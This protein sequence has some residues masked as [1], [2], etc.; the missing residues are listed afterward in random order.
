[1]ATITVQARALGSDSRLVDKIEK[2]L[3]RALRGELRLD[4]DSL[5]APIPSHLKVWMDEHPGEFQMAE[6][7]IPRP[8][9]RLIPPREP[10]K[11]VPPP[12]EIKPYVPEPDPISA[13]MHADIQRQIREAEAE[14]LL[15]DMEKQGLILCEENQTALASFLRERSLEITRANVLHFL[16][17][18]GPKLRWRSVHDVVAAL[19][20]PPLPAAAEPEEVLGFLPSGERQIS[21]KQSPP[22]NASVAVLKDY[23]KRFREANHLQFNSF[24]R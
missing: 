14:A 19:P 15:V 1:M 24:G 23:L 3:G 20:V 22:K 18:M 10:A 8:P 21:I 17:E 5:P 11:A 16:K 4:L 6:K 9:A 12:V 7:L 2:F 13:A